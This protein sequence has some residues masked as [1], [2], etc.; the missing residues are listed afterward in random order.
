MDGG[1]M[2]KV[3]LIG[4]LTA[5]PELRYTPSGTP[6]STVTV[7]VDR[8]PNKD[9][10][11]IADFIRCVVW[12]KSAENLAKYMSKGRQIAVEGR[13]QVRSWEKDGSRHWAT[14]VIAERVQYLGGKSAGDNAPMDNAAY[15]QRRDD[16]PQSQENSFA[17]PGAQRSFGD[18]GTEV[19]FSDEDLPF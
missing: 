19:S 11:V 16:Y 3:I 7:A 10:E 12:G 6:T 4:R 9:G 5:D 14:E 13:L 18:F 17:S 8:L 15:S 1:I 2:N